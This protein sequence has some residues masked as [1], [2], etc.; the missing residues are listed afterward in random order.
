MMHELA[1]I[2][3][4]DVLAFHN[5]LENSDIPADKG[6]R[7]YGLLESAVNA[8]F[9]T[10]MG[11]D[12]YPD[13]IEKAARLCYGLSC[14]HPFVDGN[15]RAAVHTMLAYLILNEAAISYTQDE[16][17]EVGMAIAKDE[18]TCDELAEWLR[19]RIV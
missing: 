6:L 19:E 15:K 12:L 1:Q 14:N 10:F 18:M 11:Q 3:I 8:P 2:I 9:Q 16:L 17:Y 13:I 7:D 5:D 4:D